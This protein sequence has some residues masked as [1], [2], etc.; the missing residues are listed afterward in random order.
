MKRKWLLGG[1]GVAAAIALAAAALAQTQAPLPVGTTTMTHEGSSTSPITKAT[2]WQHAGSDI[3]ADPA[4]V[5]GTLSNGLRYA[6]RKD[7]I[8]AGS[9]A[10]RVRIG[11]GALME[12][13]NQQGWSHLIEHMVFRGTKTYPDGDAVKIWQRLGAS[14]GRDTN[15]QTTMTATTFQLDLPRSDSASYDQ[16][17][18]VMARMMRDATI[19][20]A[21]LATEKQVVIAER[22]M[23]V[24]PLGRKVHDAGQAT[25]LT[26]LKAGE[27]DIGGTDATLG[28]ASAD[29]LRAFYK[30]WYRPDRAVVVVVGDADPQTLVAGIKRAF[31]DWQGVGPDPAKPDFGALKAPASAAALV[32]D[33]QAPDMI[34]L[35][36]M[37][38][39]DDR[40]FT[41]AHQQDQ[42]IQVVAT[43]IINQRL[44]TE[45]QKGGA[46][47][48]ADA[49][50]DTARDIAD[51]LSVAVVPKPGAW[52]AALDETFGVLNRLRT[53]PPSADE[54]AEQI[55]RIEQ[56]SR[57][58][59]EARETETSPAL[60]NEFIQDVDQGNVSAAPETYLKL[61]EAEKTALTPDAIAKSIR[62][63]LAP[64]P[65]LILL[66]P[67]A[68]DGGQQKVAA[69]LAAGKK[70]AAAQV[71]DLRP[72]SL[73]E[74]K[75]PDVTGKVVAHDA[76]AD[77]GID[78][79]RF[80]N[81]VE[82][83]YKK[84]PFEKDSIRLQVEIGHG[85][86]N[87]PPND[88]G[89]LWSSGALAAA[90][91]GPFTPDE[92]TRLTA[93][94][95]IGFAIQQLPDAL[96][97]G[98][99]TDQADIG[100]AMKLMVGALTRMDYAQTPIERLKNGY[101]ATYQ[102]YFAAPGSVLQAF[103][104]PY[105][106]GG[107]TRFRAT[108]SPSA[109]DAL[110]L[111]KFRAFW[112]Q[113]LSQG[114]IKVIAVG[115]LD[116]DKLIAAVAKTFG[117]L[118]TRP[119]DKPTTKELAVTAKWGGAKPVILHHKGD[120]DQAAVAMVYPTT[121]V[122]KDVPESVALDIA[123]SIIQDRLT[124]G[125]R[126]KE[127]G[128]YT[129][130]ADSTQA[131]DLPDYG[132]VLAG[133]QLR[134]E[135]IGDFYKALAGIVADLAAHGPSADELK[136][137][138]TTK[139]AAASRALTSNTYWLTRMSGNLDDPRYVAAVR[140]IQADIGKVDAA[141][142][143]AAVKRWLANSPDAYKIEALPEK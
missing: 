89:L 90:G 47:V 95:Q 53:T 24:S 133:A 41:I 102:A 49:S 69:A 11:V 126:E 99:R 93:G 63:Q 73:D 20:P 23:R 36:W 127:G 60:A 25:F 12:N 107:D 108:P 72:V 31:G 120:P 37:H 121:G 91:I 27:R 83:D 132:F 87:R 96:A 56:L 45:A 80:A 67:K 66:S 79:V 21:L 8:P 14:F 55:S 105:F 17:L 61:F 2:S 46:I 62:E 70:V 7:S 1:A 39:H 57:K 15:A 82:L 109:V 131:A 137:A 141:A 103:G 123:A 64:D 130:F 29:Q 113:Q 16:A 111:A 33:P 10:V 136:R 59:I 32:V 110:T 76:I 142:V 81:G 118:P 78:R 97:M 4:W 100:D 38:P 92:L 74:L 34:Q 115:D 68:V 116:P 86:Y 117:A 119:D 84:T 22:Q 129:P 138:T 140:S 122:L 85:L 6:V 88:P 104:A 124:E 65:R 44:Q 19:E 98:S 128:S 18:D 48:S 58:R 30:T 52:Q 13:D 50:Y 51:Q 9:I 54:I 112:Q 139:E 101:K 143:E 42:Y 35:A 26:G 77:L 3:P 40:P 125:F 114:P 94:R 75:V 28:A 5:T 71:A 135:R 43:A 106:H 134:V